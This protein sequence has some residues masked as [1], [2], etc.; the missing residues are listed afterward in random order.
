MLKVQVADVVVSNPRVLLWKLQQ[1]AR[2]KVIV[3]KA[4][5]TREIQSFSPVPTT[6]GFKC[7]LEAD[8]D[9]DKFQLRVTPDSTE[10][11]AS[12]VIRLVAQ[13]KNRPPAAVVVYAVV[14]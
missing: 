6:P 1:P 5:G 13:V 14:K 12:V 3:F 2:E 8:P 7:Q 10:L 9:N 4:A 11:P